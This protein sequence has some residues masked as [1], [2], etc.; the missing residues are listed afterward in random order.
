VLFVGL[1]GAVGAG[2][3]EV[4][5]I[6]S[7]SRVPVFST[8]A[9]GH[10]ILESEPI[11]RRLVQRYGKGL[12][13][14][15]GTVNR[16]VL[17]EKVFKKSREPQWME[18]LLHPAIRREVFRWKSSLL[19]RSRPPALAVVEV[20]LLHES[21]WTSLF[22]G[23]LCVTASSI[24]RRKRLRRRGW[25]DAETRRREKRQWTGSRK[26][27]SSDWRV[28]NNGNRKQLQ[29]VVSAWRQAVLVRRKV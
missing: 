10:R 13:G 21:R 9:A 5:R 1:T 6:L 22:D 8:D 12:L 3:S 25:S 17:A 2:K 20:P 28:P 7:R 24:L 27:H 18:R 4:S 23:V 19:K 29:E 15:R 11:K 16:K 26:A 14:P